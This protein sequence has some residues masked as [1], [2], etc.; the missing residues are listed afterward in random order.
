MRIEGINAL[1]IAMLTNPVSSNNA[2]ATTSA[3][4]QAEAQVQETQ[5]LMLKTLEF[6]FYKQ[7][8]M[9]VKLVRIVGDLYQGRNLDSMA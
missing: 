9:N 1:N 3:N 8:D 6:A 7:Q 5:E 2:S 4:A